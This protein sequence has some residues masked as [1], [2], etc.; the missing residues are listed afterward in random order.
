MT[1][2]LFILTES[3]DEGVM[4]MWHFQVASKYEMAQFIIKNL[5]RY[6]NMGMFDGISWQSGLYCWYRSQ[7]LTP[8]SLL[9]AIDNSSID[10]DSESRFEIHEIDLSQNGEKAE[11]ATWT[12]KT[13]LAELATLHSSSSSL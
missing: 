13:E 8:E 9:E 6:D 11:E 3:I 10:G 12:S 1:N 7:P 5:S 2:K 4:H